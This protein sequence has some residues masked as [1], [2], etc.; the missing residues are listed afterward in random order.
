MRNYLVADRYARGLDRALPND[1]ERE[2]AM[3]ALSDVAEIYRRDHTLR[4][5]L[6]HPGIPLEQR[7]ALLAEVLDRAGALALLKKLLDVM[8]RRGRIAL[9]PDVAALFAAT[10]DLRLNRTGA[11]VTTAVPME[12][13]Q[14]ERIIKTLESHS[15]MK[16]RADF[17]V[18]PEILGG[19]IARIRGTV[20]DGSLRAR[21]QRLKQS[22]LP[23]EKVGG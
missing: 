1:T 15:G 16:V 6:S 21:V 18:D 12:A 4:S 22:L 19:V 3:Q 14:A 5:A 10:T 8:L 13:D 11:T 17:E 20:I 23:E 7:A 2:A 9:L